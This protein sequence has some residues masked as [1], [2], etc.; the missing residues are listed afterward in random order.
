M[1]EGERG[2]EGERKRFNSDV[3]CVTPARSNDNDT[4]K[5]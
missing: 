5:G 3:T 4:R 2:D 1:V